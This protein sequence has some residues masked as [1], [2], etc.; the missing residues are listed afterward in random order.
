MIK[1]PALGE[2][3]R[4]ALVA[5][6]G[7][8]TAARIQ[9]SFERCRAF[10]FVPVVARFARLRHGYLAGPDPSRAADMQ[11]ALDDPAIDGV[12]ALRGGYGT[13]RILPDL[14]LSAVLER[15]KPFIGFSDNTG[16]HLA[17][18]RAG[19]VSFH[20]PHAGF[21]SFPPW[22]MQAFERVVCRTEPAGEL[23][24]SGTGPRTITL[25]GGCAEGRLLGGNLSLLAAACGTPF[26]PECAGT[27][28]AIEDVS[29]PVYRIDR[30]LT[31]L[32][33]SGALD[34]VAGIAFGRFTKVR[35]MRDDLPLERV[36]GE[37][38]DDLDVPVAAHLP[39][40]HV[41]RNLTLPLGCRTRLDADAHT[42][43]ILENAVEPR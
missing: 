18:A 31:Q 36:L 41:A 34:G 1:P 25:R 15:P 21:D 11:Q 42:L 10:G 35:R 43:T 28:L 19:L 8:V 2:G 29:E 24:A 5:P 37:L 14:D 38:A 22:A 3:S 32:R 39:F 4:V 17:L 13:M 20:G 26:Q 16:V 23:P 27:I 12:W 33:Q 7:P 30:M 6:A 9:R 40:G